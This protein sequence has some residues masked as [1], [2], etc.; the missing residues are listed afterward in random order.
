MTGGEGALTRSRVTVLVD[1]QTASAA[2]RLA[3][4]LEETGRGRIVGEPTQGK[5]RFQAARVLPG[6]VTVLVSKGQT[7]DRQGR[8]LQD[9]GLS[10]RERSLSGATDPGNGKRAP[11]PKN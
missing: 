8:P 4:T 1:E 5:G 7:L 6:G 3:L 2:E 11:A 10:P 9:R